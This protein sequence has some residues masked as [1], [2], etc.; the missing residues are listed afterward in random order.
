MFPPSSF[1]FVRAMQ[2][3]SGYERIKPSTQN[4]AI[5][6][7]QYP[8]KSPPPYKYPAQKPQRGGREPQ[9]MTTQHTK[10]VETSKY[11]AKTASPS[12]RTT[13]SEAEW[14]VTSGPEIPLKPNATSANAKSVIPHGGAM[15][16]KTP[17]SISSRNQMPPP[18]NGS[19][20]KYQM[21]G[22]VPQPNP[23]IES[24]QFQVQV[25]L[26]TANGLPASAPPTNFVPMV[27]KGPGQSATFRVSVHT[28]PVA[29]TTESGPVSRGYPG[30]QSGGHR[31]PPEP[32]MDSPDSSAA[33]PPSYY[34]R[35]YPRIE[36][37]PPPYQSSSSSRT[38]AP[39]SE[40]SQSSSQSYY[41]S[42]PGYRQTRAPTMDQWCHPKAPSVDDNMSISSDG[43][44]SRSSSAED[45][46]FAGFEL[47]SMTSFDGGDED[48]P[49]V[50]TNE[51]GTLVVH[52]RKRP[53]I[54]VLNPEPLMNGEARSQRPH[55][56]PETYKFY[57]EQRVENVLKDRKEREHRR[58][59][60]EQEMQKVNLSEDAQSQMRKLLSKKESNY[61]RLKRSKMDP[62]MFR[63]VQVIGVGAFGE[64]CLTTHVQSG[65]FYAMKILK[66]SEVLK[67]N[68][69]AHVKAERDILAEADNEWVVKLFY[70]FQD[71][72]NL[73]F[74]ME[75]VQGG[76]LMSLLIKEG[77]FREEMAR[78]YIAE[79][80]LAIESVH[81]MGFIHRDIKPDNVLID[82][83]GHIKLTDFGLCTGFRWTHD[84]KYYQN[85]T[86]SR[87]HSRNPSMDYDESWAK[88]HKCRCGHAMD[89]QKPL[90]R[91]HIRQHMRCQAHS[92]VGT[93]NYIAPEVLMRIPYTHLCDWW[94]VGVIL[95]E[96]LVGR[97]PFYSP[98]AAETQ[99]KVCYIVCSIP[100]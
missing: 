30:M 74:V 14:K 6:Q 57:M 87:N 48:A 89:G 67:R 25:S 22:Y 93:P 50:L 35:N 95:Y 11:M 29:M 75:Y 63:K 37:S 72:D 8:T 24:P 28:S 76:D 79:L 64:V 31:R 5:S 44:D 86:L 53:E 83:D 55:I 77:F 73:Y 17:Y 9:Q 71:K 90:A 1:D 84:S 85:G 21:G 3:N 97:P 32:A 62:S 51:T 99:M 43:S 91:R 49:N 2:T 13:I 58:F 80:V 56:S 7:M 98:N 61:I 68:Q 52:V 82:S 47:A 33:F 92:L 40:S 94:S 19:H 16:K 39:P 38:S 18:A 70:S 60:L 45:V 15:W 41:D 34:A 26:N 100:I 88:E 42:P 69:V 66:K 65:S 4:A 59:Q 27:S 23:P 78:F 20:G 54:D 96:M 10:K 81:R 12:G 46:D 36:K